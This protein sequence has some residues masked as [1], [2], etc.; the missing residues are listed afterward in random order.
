MVSSGLSTAG[1]FDLRQVGW[2]ANPSLVASQLK[3]LG[4]LPDLDGWQVVFS[5]LGDVA[6]RQHA[7]PLPQQTTLESYW[8]AICR[9]SGA[10][11][12]R[13][14]TTARPQLAS[15]VT[16]PA[17]VVPV[18]VV[19]SVRGPN[20]ASVATTVPNALLFQFNSSVLVPSADA[21][22]Q[23]IAQRARHQ[24]QLISITGYASPDGGSAAYN[25]E[26]SLLR[27][28]AV[29]T[30]L[31]ALGLPAGQI[32]QV[33]GLGADGKTIQACKVAGKFDE[34]VCAQLRHVVIVL[35][36]AKTNS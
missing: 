16:N 3:A 25:T 29:R 31:I 30:R 34:A 1:G 14:D 12:C 6:G 15:H 35:W 26:L 4:L 7:L 20:S 33:K 19:A 28:R 17:P 22:L 21:I 18:P 8:T 10:A 24:R 36:P 27:A 11:S 9:A 13:V 2:D 32:A 23:P 5:G